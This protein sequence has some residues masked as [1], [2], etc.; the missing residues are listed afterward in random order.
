MAIT[1][2]V[3]DGWRELHGSEYPDILA[4]TDSLRSDDG[5]H[6]TAF[7]WVRDHG[8]DAVDVVIEEEWTPTDIDPSE[9]AN[10]AVPVIDM[11]VTLGEA[12]RA[13]DDAGDAWL[14]WAQTPDDRSA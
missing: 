13:V 8:T 12:Q 2:D 7:L 10:T 14:S 11:T 1:L 5:V 3:P 4:Q 6:L 9:Y